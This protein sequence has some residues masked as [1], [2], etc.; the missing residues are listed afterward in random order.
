[1]LESA[2]KSPPEMQPELRVA[3]KRFEEYLC[4]LLGSIEIDERFPLE[5]CESIDEWD[6]G[7]KRAEY[8]K[9]EA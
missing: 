4:L 9:Q 2:F 7:D 8:E 6:S 5:T 3:F 1:V